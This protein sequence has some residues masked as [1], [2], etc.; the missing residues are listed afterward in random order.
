MKRSGGPG[1]IPFELAGTSE[2]ANR[3]LEAWQDEGRAA[4]R[5]SL[6]LDY[7]FPAS[8]SL[9]QALAC[10]EAAETFYERGASKL[11]AIGAPIA[12]AQFVAAVC[13]YGENTAL[14]LILAGRNGR[15]PQLARR[16]A[17]VKFALLSTGWSYVLL[18]IGHAAPRGK[19]HDRGGG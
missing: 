9:M 12:W 18:A 14:L 3:I 17:L 5:L 16:A 2:R 8:Y 11:A 6:L 19:H 4:A 7:P 1:I 10:S 13:D 15:L